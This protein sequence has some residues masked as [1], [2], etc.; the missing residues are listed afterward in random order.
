MIARSG[1]GLL[2][3]LVAALVVGLVASLGDARPS[4]AQE[5]DPV[6]VVE[7]LFAAFKEGVPTGDGAAIA[8]LFTED[9]FVTFVEGGESFGVFGRPAMEP[10]F[11]EEPDAEFQVTIVDIAASGGQVTGK[12]E[13]RDTAVIEAGFER[14]VA[15]FVAV[16][17]GG[18]VASFEVTDDLSD[19][20]TADYADFVASQPDEGEDGEVPPDGVE[21]TMG[22]EQPG[23]AFL[24]PFSGVT[25]SGLE[26]AA[27]PEGVLQPAGIHEGTCEAP[28]EL[29]TRVAGAL[30]GGSFSAFSVA[31]DDLLAS[32]HVLAVAASESD[33]ET[34]VACGAI[35]QAAEP[36]PTQ[37][38]GAQLPTSGT[39][40]AAGN[41]APLWA[42]L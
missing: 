36:A 15:D 24:F 19:P 34:I 14:R 31:L 25:S 28:G 27:G 16:V 5:E 7:A 35:E 23:Q 32:P 40:G 26:I 8:A 17:E 12:A 33:T 9:G 20:E 4:E 6:A 42:L 30:N 10:V 29:V 2:A 1:R 18:L 22:G 3:A 21:V 39:G 11:S 13:V 41:D 38:P 37:A